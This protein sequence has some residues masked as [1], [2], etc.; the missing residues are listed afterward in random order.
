MQREFNTF[1]NVGKPQVVYRESIER[2]FEASAVFDKEVSGQKH[3]AEVAIR[4][5][6][7]ARAEPEICS[8]LKSIR[9]PYPR[10]LFRLLNAVCLKH[11]RAA[12]CSDIR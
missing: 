12:P 5:R 7:R 4:L 10:I 3:F 8:G 1:V 6:P 11:F 2:D 9:K